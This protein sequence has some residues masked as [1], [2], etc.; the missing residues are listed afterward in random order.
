MAGNCPGRAPAVPFVLCNRGS[1]GK[2]I[3]LAR[4][5]SV[6]VMMRITARIVNLPVPA[7]GMAIIRTP[8]ADMD[9]EAW[10]PR[11]I[12]RRRAIINLLHRCLRILRIVGLRLFFVVRLGRI[13]AWRCCLRWM[14]I[15]DQRTDDHGAENPGSN[16]CALM[17]A[18]MI[19][20]DCSSGGGR[21]KCA[22]QCKCGNDFNAGHD[23]IPSISDALTARDD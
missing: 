10:L 12:L 1:P 21:G 16:R 9:A 14:R 8:T 11:L 6:R 13:I 17:V 19:A 5:R 7:V 3:C 20:R 18:G 23:E 15:G 22:S 4:G 2:I